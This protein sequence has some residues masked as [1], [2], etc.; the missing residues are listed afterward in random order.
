M[1]KNIIDSNN[2]FSLYIDYNGMNL[3]IWG[4]CIAGQ[5]SWFYIKQFQIFINCGTL[6]KNFN[7]IC[8][9]L[10]SNTKNN[11]EYL[12][13]NTY[14]LEN[15]CQIIAPDE[16]S[17]SQ[18]F[19]Q[20]VKNINSS[21][22]WRNTGKETLKHFRA[23]IEEINIIR[24]K[25][26]YKYFN[27]VR[28]FNSFGDAGYT[29]SIG[30]KSLIAYLFNLDNKFIT[31][32]L[33]LLETFPIIMIEY[34]SINLYFNELSEFINSLPNSKFIFHKFPIKYYNSYNLLKEEFKSLNS[35]NYYLWF[36]REI[37]SPKF[38]QAEILEKYYSEYYNNYVQHEYS[39]PIRCC[40]KRKNRK[41][42]DISEAKDSLDYFNSIA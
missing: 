23:Y 28:L 33:E 2:Y 8:V 15:I 13:H 32:N 3:E 18:Y 5:E 34:D 20:T 11:Y 24:R 35:Y 36:E 9:L 29:V 38:I 14:E 40:S 42:I 10:T 30:K 39:K 21:L 7:P 27:F 16:K 26:K 17:L 19:N 22:S 12:K 25:F 1:K 41:K 37:Y 31:D 4:N 6:V